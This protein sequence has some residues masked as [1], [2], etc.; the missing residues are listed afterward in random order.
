[1]KEPNRERKNEI[2]AINAISL[3]EEQKEA[4]AKGTELIESAKQ[5]KQKTL[6]EPP[7]DFVKAINSPVGYVTGAA[8]LAALTAGA[9]YAFGKAKSGLSG[10]NQRMTD[11]VK[12]VMDKTSKELM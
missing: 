3:N 4:Q 12:R 2:K 9:G 1:M 6:E 7:F 8:A 5:E 10:I 11:L